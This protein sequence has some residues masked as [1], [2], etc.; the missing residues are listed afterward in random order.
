MGKIIVHSFKECSNV[1]MCY[2]LD[3]HVYIYQVGMDVTYFQQLKCF[4]FH[5]WYDN[6]VLDDLIDCASRDQIVCILLILFNN[7]T[8]AHEEVVDLNSDGGLNFRVS[9]SFLFT[10]S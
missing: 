8:Y 3:I 9:E 5:H 6:N 4:L 10:A 7:A 2:E 1:F